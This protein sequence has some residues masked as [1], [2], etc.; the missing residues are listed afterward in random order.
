MSGIQKL[1]Y[2]CAGG[3]LW[4]VQD[5]TIEKW[6]FQVFGNKLVTKIVGCRYEMSNNLVYRS[7]KKTA[8]PHITM[9]VKYMSLQRAGHVP[10]IGRG[11]GMKKVDTW[12]T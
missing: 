5:Q 4:D 2:C 6:K 1:P 11:Q 12:K 8:L 3:G 10:R 7:M 9:K